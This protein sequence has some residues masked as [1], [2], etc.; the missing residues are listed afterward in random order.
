MAM[1]IIAENPNGFIIDMSK[2][3]LANLIGYYSNDNGDFKKLRDDCVLKVG[4]EIAISKMYELLYS[5]RSNEQR[6]KK[7]SEL[8]AKIS[9]TLLL[10]DPVVRQIQSEIIE[11][12]GK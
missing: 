11:Q 1:K 6:F 12:T 3:E 5:M 2:T 9:E 7:A 10:V 4:S 8:L